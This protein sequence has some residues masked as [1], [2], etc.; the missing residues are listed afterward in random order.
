MSSKIKI[1]IITACFNSEKYIEQ[2]IQ[3]VINQTYDNI[4]Y[5][6][7]DGKSKDNTMDIVNKYRDKID[8]IVTEEDEGIYD[9]FNKGV[10]LA[11]GDYVYF[12]NSDDYLIGPQVI[13]N[14]AKHIKLSKL[15]SCKIIY[16]NILL[17][18]EENGF[19]KIFGQKISIENFK[20]DI[21][22]PH[23]GVFLKKEVF[24]EFQGFDLQYNI[25]SDFDLLLKVFEKYEKQSLYI[26]EV[27]AVFRTVGFSSSMDNR[28]KLREERHSIIN[29]HFNHFP[30]Q[31]S[32]IEDSIFY[33]K[34]WVEVNL[35]TGRNITKYLQAN[36]IS[37]TVLFGTTDL[38]L[39]LMKDMKESNIETIALL[40]NDPKRHGIVMN[41]VI[42]SSP[43]WLA[44]NKDQFDLIILSFEGKYEEEVRRQIY[45]LCGLKNNV[46][47]W[48]EIIQNNYP[49]DK[50]RDNVGI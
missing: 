46:I 19:K 8:I 26:D 28:D 43:T 40:D 12:L 3:S 41:G 27:I 35:Y 45:E 20:N 44:H 32:S 34:K 13:E 31:P 30:P 49:L 10:S 15:K 4:E 6:I 9:A 36:G 18:N 1:T 38:S 47:S 39:Y 37:K 23:Q 42:I 25:A 2:T 7:V 11:N 14:V 50:I 17:I 48:K 29:K 33:Y 16:G 24:F 21:M 22:P 5:I